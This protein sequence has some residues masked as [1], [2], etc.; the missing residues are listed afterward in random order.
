LILSKLAF[1][2]GVAASDW[3]RTFANVPG[4]LAALRNLFKFFL[5]RKARNGS[6]RSGSVIFVD[7]NGN[8]G[9]SEVS[10]L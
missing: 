8:S 7:P 9:G 4:N 5:A 10:K 2:M 1:V 3:R 6:R